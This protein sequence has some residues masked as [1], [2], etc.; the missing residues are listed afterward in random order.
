MLV[1]GLCAVA[2]SA[3]LGGGRGALRQDEGRRQ[4]V[5]RPLGTGLFEK[6]TKKYVIKYSKRFTEIGLGF[7]LKKKLE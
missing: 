2:Q 5:D 6:I 3:G 4:H 7:A 1:G